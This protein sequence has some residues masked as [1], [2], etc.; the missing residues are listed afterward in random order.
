MKRPNW[1]PTYWCGMAKIAA[2][3]R[4]LDCT[5]EVID[6]GGLTLLPSFVDLHCHFRDPGF[7]QKEDIETGLPGGGKRRLYR[8]EFDGQHQSGVQRHGNG[9]L[10]AA[11][12]GVDRAGGRAPVRIGNRGL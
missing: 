8:C 10:C 7:T 5:G 6:A 12:S 3:G 11:K 2:I 9:S 4:G 1:L